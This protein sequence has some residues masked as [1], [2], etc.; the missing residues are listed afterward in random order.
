M[1]A[2]VRPAS[3]RTGAP[4]PRPRPRDRTATLPAGAGAAAAGA[5]GVAAPPRIAWPFRLIA[6]VVAV[7]LGLVA[8]VYPARRFDF[9][10]GQRLLDVLVGTGYSRYWRVL[11]I[12]PVWALVTAVLVQLMLIGMRKL[13][14]RRRAIVGAREPSG[15]EPGGNSSRASR[16]DARGSR[17]RSR[18]RPRS[19]G[20][21]E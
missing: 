7:P 19:G 20:V 6:W 4:T 15:G 13:G 2:Q 1:P 16:R 9:L 14:D 18:R 21:R 5:G 3:P 11:V 12:A 17:S 8:V 10:S